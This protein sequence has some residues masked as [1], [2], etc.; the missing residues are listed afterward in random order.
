MRTAIAVEW[1]KLRRSRV[2][3]V[4]TAVLAGLLPVLAAGFMAAYLTGGDSQLAVKARGSVSGSTWW[5]YLSLDAQLLSVGAL[6]GVGVVVCWT[7]GREF[8]DGTVAGLFALPVSRAQIAW[9][10]ALVVLGWGLA[11]SV[12]AALVAIPLGVLLDLGWPSGWASLATRPSGSASRVE[13]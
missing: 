5:D 1:L 2:V 11:T 12:L 8:S 7:Y 4:T 6:L 9:A 13:R 3:V 10:K